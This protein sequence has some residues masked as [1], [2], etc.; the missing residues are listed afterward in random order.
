M[1]SS[2]AL[3]P[4]SRSVVR[5]AP[6]LRPLAAAAVLAV[7]NQ[8]VAA[9]D[10]GERVADDSVT[11]GVGQV[12]LL[13]GQVRVLRKDGFAEPLRRGMSVHVGDRVETSSS[14]H[15]HL[16]FVDN[17]AVSVRPD[18]VL[19]IQAYHF[20]AKQPASSEVRLQVDHGITRSI[21]GRATEVDKNRFR[22]NTP[23]AAIGVRG[24][25]FI[26]QATEAG[27]RASVV[28][29]AIV[30]SA[31]GEGCSAASLGPCAGAQAQQLSADMSHL[32][33]ELQRGD[34]AARLV[35]VADVMQ[36]AGATGAEGRLAAM[37]AAESA[38]R[39]AGILAA[40]P[41]GRNDAAAAE[42]LVL[43]EGSLSDPDPNPNVNPGVNPIPN[44]NPL[45]HPNPNPNPSVNPNPN[46]NPSV[47]LNSRPSLDARLLW[48]RYT[49]GAASNDDVS[50][51]FAIA[52]L[53]RHAAI[54][55][56]RLT[57][58]R[59]DDPANPGRELRAGEGQV[60]FRLSRAQATFENAGAVEAAIVHG[61]ALSL[62]F[63]RRTFA[64]ALALSAPSAGKTELRMAGDVRGDGTFSVRDQDSRQS[65][66][67]AV[68]L[69]GKEAGYLFE[70]GLGSGLF[71]GTTLWGR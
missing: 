37:R 43:A 60:D 9:A 51:P 59:A 38:A 11:R 15:V 48:G 52:R 39:N 19:E 42:A 46:P 29:G 5:W 23:V 31:L 1:I 8:P 26:V 54:G 70:R 63:T 12:S 14:G 18:S 50:V 32:M 65:V 61:G 16:R 49:V 67:G 35:P 22:M 27:M 20:D 45:P 58:F 64:T 2:S 36:A 44:P 57:L 3:R 4:G 6:G 24:T 10:P 28:E 40:V 68:S 41:Y 62:D 21:S 7:L 13:V 55:S 17:G 33:V 56:E 25:D 66:A 69:D 30:V 53:G 47:N 71:R 34:Q